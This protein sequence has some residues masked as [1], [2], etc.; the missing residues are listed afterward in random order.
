[1]SSQ[2]H[3][4]SLATAQANSAAVQ[5]QQQLAAAQQS[6]SSYYQNVLLSRQVAQRKLMNKFIGVLRGKTPKSVQWEEKAE[7]EVILHWVKQVTAFVCGVAFACFPLRGFGAYLSFGVCFVGIT[8]SIMRKLDIT[9]DVMTR[10]EALQEGFMA[11]FATFTLF[12][13]VCYSTFRY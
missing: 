1:M 3:Q 13:V 10:W 12:W 6:S 4:K 8:L 7:V 11:A 2:S 5:Q 9:D